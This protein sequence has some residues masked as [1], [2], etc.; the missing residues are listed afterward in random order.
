MMS[1]KTPNTVSQLTEIL[2]S[3][4]ESID[5]LVKQS[6]PSWD[7]LIRPLEALDDRLHQFWSPISHLNS[8]ANTPELRAVYNACLPALSEYRSKIGQNTKL[9]EAYQAIQESSEF[10]RLNYAQ[11]KVITHALRDFKLSGVALNTSDRE[12][13]AALEQKLSQLQTKFSENVLDATRSW[14][15]TITDPKKLEGLPEH[16]LLNAKTTAQQHHQIGY[17]FGLD[18]PS[19]QAIMTYAQDA[20]LRETFYHA[21]VTRASDQGSVSAWDNTNIIESIL[22]CR[23]QLA[24]LL[25]F[26]NYAEYSL[27]TKMAR[28]PQEVIDFLDNLLKVTRPIAVNEYADLVEFAKE[29]TDKPLHPW[30]IAFYTE[31]L[32]KARYDLSPEDLRPYF[33]IERVLSGL[34]KMVELL[35]GITVNEKAAPNKWD[36]AVRFF[37]IR[38]KSHQ[39]KGEFYI[40]LYA[41]SQKRE[42]AWMGECQNQRRL[43]NGELQSPIAYIITNF[44][45][46]TP[47]RPALLTHSEVEIL[48]HEFGHGLHHM[49]SK[50]EYT[51]VSG[52]R[53]VPWDAVELPSQFMENFCW[54]PKGLSFISG[55]YETGETLPITMLEKLK[56]AKNFQSALQIIRQLELAL[57]D[58]RL[59]SQAP[60]N[61]QALLNRIRQ[62][63]AVIPTVDYNRFQHGFSHIFAG[64]YA[65]GYYSYLWAEVLACDAFSKFEQEGIFNPE[66]GQAFLRTV[67]EQGGAIDPSELFLEFRG[68]PPSLE[69]LLRDKGLMPQ[70]A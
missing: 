10:D 42:G 58:F 48:F 26:S 18:F 19:Y 9:Y 27:A 50:I 24:T 61:T 65:A 57:F 35:Y 14:S 31:K 20:H 12:T 45:A 59:H 34:F 2:Q 44:S 53:G 52:I 22:E 4:L 49:L 25:G 46:P 1:I 23:H 21:Y 68:R 16:A 55:H 32:R 67:L 39:L 40:D 30:D 33:P 5:Q 54:D 64:G 51:D 8:V 6:E 56:A 17:R 28:T 15:M 70:S 29:Y 38:D 63:V 3:N 41:R 66:T 36:K 69:P 60:M 37:E 7:S 43:E 47:E 13:F 62:E 11:K